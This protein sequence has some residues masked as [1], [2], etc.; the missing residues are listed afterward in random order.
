MLECVCFAFFYIF[1][2]GHDD[3]KWLGYVASTGMICTNLLLIVSGV[4]LIQSIKKIMQ[5][6]STNH[7]VGKIDV[8]MLYI[9]ATSFGLFVMG[10]FI[11]TAANVAYLVKPTIRIEIV[12]LVCSIIQA[13][14]SF[15]SQC[16]LCVIF[17]GIS[18][19]K[20]AIKEEKSEVSM[21]TTS[22]QTEPEYIH[23]IAV[24]EFDE[25]AEL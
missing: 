1:E 9:H 25:D 11:F 15:V 16:L 24:E 14:F 2:F 8:K 23:T 6:F 21:S 3:K 19:R 20:T 18:K 7:R 13:T 5:Y 22:D 12:L 17:W 10:Y 4:L